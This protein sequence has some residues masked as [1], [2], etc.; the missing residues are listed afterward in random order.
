L[1]SSNLHAFDL[2]E[3]DFIGA[4][5]VEQGSAGEQFGFAADGAEQRAFGISGKTG[6]LDIAVRYASRL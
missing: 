6:A 1:P 3:G 4:A 2:I 5:V